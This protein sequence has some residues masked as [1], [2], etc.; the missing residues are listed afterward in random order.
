LRAELVEM[1]VQTDLKFQQATEESDRRFAATEKQTRSIAHIVTQVIRS[2]MQ[3]T[4]REEIQLNNAI[5]ESKFE[6]A[7][8][9]KAKHGS[10]SSPVL[11]ASQTVSTFCTGPV[12]NKGVPP[13]DDSE[14]LKRDNMFYFSRS[15]CPSF[16]D[17]NLIEWLHKCQFFFDLHQV[18]V[19]YRT[20]LATI[21]FRDEAS[22]WYDGYLIDHEPPN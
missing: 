16:N 21:L 11:I 13:S 5:L 18:P 6:R 8:G 22:D 19:P 1:R 14:F 10:C 2:E 4:I 3:S 15:D 7:Q 12:P 17:T 9:A 20:H